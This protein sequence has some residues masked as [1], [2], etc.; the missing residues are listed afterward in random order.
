MPRYSGSSGKPALGS[1]PL[2]VSRVRENRDASATP[3]SRVFVSW[4][5]SRKRLFKIEEILWRRV[6]VRIDDS[7]ECNKIHRLTGR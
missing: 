6:I 4:R 3:S 7:D 2:A 1:S 5:A